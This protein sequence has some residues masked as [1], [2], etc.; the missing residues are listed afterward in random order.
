MMEAQA[1]FYP[2]GIL[3]LWTLAILVVVGNRRMAA[4]SQGLMPASYYKLYRGAEEPPRLAAL[5][6]HYQNLLELPPLFYVTTLVAFVAGAVDP[7]MVGLAWAFVGSRMV[8]SI[9]HVTVN[10]VPIRFLLFLSGVVILA[11]MLILILVR[12]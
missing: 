4:V 12:L 1:I 5:A 8:H 2:V 9:V 3:I 10:K 11:A 6:R 7:L